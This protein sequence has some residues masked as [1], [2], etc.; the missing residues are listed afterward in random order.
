MSNL[1][2]SYLRGIYDAA[3]GLAQQH[4]LGQVLELA[5]GQVVVVFAYGFEDEVLE[6]IQEQY[7]RWLRPVDCGRSI[8]LEKI[9]AWK[10]T[11]KGQG[12]PDGYLQAIE[13]KLAN[14]LAEFDNPRFGHP[15][16]SYLWN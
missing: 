7:G 10:C 8:V 3:E 14:L 11:L 16:F 9:D 12:L 6:F 13:T 2:K 5:A 1:N 15:R 4:G